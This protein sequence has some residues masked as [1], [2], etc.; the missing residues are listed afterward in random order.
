M[1]ALFFALFLSLLT[2]VSFAEEPTQLAATNNTSIVTAPASE[3]NLQ[4]NK[5]YFFA[6]SMCQNCKDAFVYL[7]QHHSD[8]EIP[9]TDM[10]FHHNFELYKQCV[11]K[12]NVTNSELRLPLI[13][14]GDKYIMG[15]DQTSGPL[16]DKYLTE[17]QSAN[18]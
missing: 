16:F 7:S 4:E 9:I 3:E 11:K 13:C 2:S 1:K 6:H 8:L 18:Q 10:K 12:F 17:F 15:W 14:M 5:I